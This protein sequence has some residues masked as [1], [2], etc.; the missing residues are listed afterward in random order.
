MDYRIHFALNCG[1][2]S[3][4]AISFYSAKTLDQQLT[5]AENNFIEQYMLEGEEVQIQEDLSINNPH[6][7]HP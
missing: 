4:P 2:K 1:A 6:F 7:Q 3:C 5:T